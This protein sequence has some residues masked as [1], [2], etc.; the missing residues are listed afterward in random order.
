MIEKLLVILEKQEGNLNKLLK[1]VL[2]KQVALVNNNNEGIKD[3]VSKEEKLLLTVQL[4]E[5]MRLKVME[6][7]FTK[8]QIDNERYKLSIM[9]ENLK[10][11]IDEKLIHNITMYEQR[12]KKVIKEV[13]KINQQNMLLIQQSRSLIND[14]IT[15]VLNL[16]N[17]TIVDR[18]A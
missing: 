17:R 1:F 4:A 7:I 10:E 8:Y 6:E 5:E 12:I 18:K 3:S 13:Q 14:T 11:K 2:E 15:A 9:I 16:N